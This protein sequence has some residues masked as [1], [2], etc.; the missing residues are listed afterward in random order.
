MSGFVT[1]RNVVLYTRSTVWVIDLSERTLSRSARVDV[2]TDVATNARQWLDSQESRGLPLVASYE[3]AGAVVGWGGEVSL[4]FMLDGGVPL[5][6]GTITAVSG[7]LEE[8][9]RP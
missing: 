6:T 2:E 1:V 3:S 5:Q 9:V 8:V 4:M 7:T